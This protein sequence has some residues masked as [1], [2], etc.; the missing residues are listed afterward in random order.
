M[1]IAEFQISLL[2]NQPFAKA[3]LRRKMPAL[4][5]ERSNAAKGHRLR[6]LVECMDTKTVSYTHLTLPTKA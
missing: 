5:M 3:N 1:E 4:R 6:E 2:L